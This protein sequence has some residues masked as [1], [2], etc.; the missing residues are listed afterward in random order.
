MVYDVF[1]G[2][3]RIHFLRTAQMGHND[4]GT[5]AGEHL[6][7][8]R[9]GPTDT[10]VVRNLEVFVQGD[11]EIYAHDGFFAGKIVAVNK[12]LHN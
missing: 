9:H 2:E 3:L 1:Q 4:N 12:L 7:K 8:G 6:F 10:G 5:S 11:V